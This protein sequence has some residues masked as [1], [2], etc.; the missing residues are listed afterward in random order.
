MTVVVVVIVVVIVMVV[1]VVVEVHWNA[2]FHG[3]RH[4]FLMVHRD[5]LLIYIDQ[6][7]LES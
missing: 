2:Y 4:W 6:M 1:V 5:M 7:E 3:V